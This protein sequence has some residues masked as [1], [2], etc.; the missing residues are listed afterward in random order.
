MSERLSH[1]EH[2]KIARALEVHHALFERVW[3]MS[4]IR[5]SKRVP[6]AGVLFNKKGDCIDFIVNKEFWE[7]L[8]FI[9]KCFVISH[10]CFHIAL[11]H[12]ARTRELKTRRLRKISNI[13]QDLVINHALVNRY[14][15]K[16]EEVDPEN[17]YCWVDRV[18]E[19]LL[20]ETFAD[21]ENYEYYFNILVRMAEEQPEKFQEM[22]GKSETVDDHDLGDQIGEEGEGEGE[23]GEGESDDSKDDGKGDKSDEGD[24]GDLDPDEF[25]Y[26]DPNEYSDDFSDAIGK[27]DEDLT[28]DEK[29][30]LENFI[31]ENENS[32]GDPKENPEVKPTGKSKPG[33]PGKDGGTQ[34]GTTAGTGW[35]FAKEVKE[36]KK[37]KFE[38]IV[39]SWARKKMN[40]EYLEEDQ[41]VHRNRRFTMVDTGLMLPTEYETLTRKPEIDKIEVWFFQDTSGSCTG[42]TDRFFGIAEG[43]PLDRFNMRMFCFDTKVYE[44]NLIDRKLYGFGG[45]Y[46]SILEERIQEELTNDPKFIYPEAVFV[47]TDGFG[48]EIVPDKPKNWHWILTP[49]GSRDCIPDA[50]SFYDLAAY[51]A[52]EAA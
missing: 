12:G 29:E 26:F 2:F 35:T 6:T 45:T 18:F 34:A 42:Y 1:Q 46:F 14:G 13:A 50:C 20:P 11:N 44:T 28:S 43:M 4:R 49:N 40:P 7:G 10:E 52:V 9:I 48:N 5:F 31:N 36:P 30:T 41:W 8:S 38:H 16:R 15:Y 24:P 17:K 23:E 27:L 22:A 47:V 51:E 19:S 21:D 33:K 25:D 32:N 37:H 39:T 3:T